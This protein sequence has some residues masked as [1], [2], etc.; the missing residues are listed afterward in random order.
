MEATRE[1]RESEAERFHE[2]FD[3]ASTHSVPSAPHDRVL[4]LQR[5]AGNAAV[6]RLLR[7][8]AGALLQRDNS[9]A[10]H[11][12]G[13]TKDEVQAALN[14][15]QKTS[16]PVVAAARAK[17]EAEGKTALAQTTDFSALEPDRP[18]GEV[19][20]KR[21]QLTD[22][23]VDQAFRRAWLK[24]FGVPIKNAVLALLIGQWSAETGNSA[25]YDNNLGN[26]TVSPAAESDYSWRSAAEVGKG[27]TPIKE[28][29]RYGAY[30][31]PMQGAM[32]LIHHQIAKGPAMWAA[33][34]SGDVSDYV[35]VM[36]SFGYF[37]GPIQRVEVVKE[38]KT[39]LISHGYLANVKQNLPRFE[40]PPDA[41]LGSRPFWGSVE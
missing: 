18:R 11:V 32:A 27:G 10:Y 35:H 9:D 19:T 13:L 23:E 16:A 36:K 34:Q 25:I 7:G 17:Y 26:L 22:T 5:T 20:G 21:T 3:T 28:R 4:A 1:P 40:V 33:L 38:G 6:T 30:A 14:V 8:R 12:P 39:Y 41:S 37:T 31:T 15:E 29:Q 24:I 2:P